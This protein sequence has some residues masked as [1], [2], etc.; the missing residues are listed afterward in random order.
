MGRMMRVIMTAG[1]V[2]NLG[3]VTLARLMTALRLGHCDQARC[4]QDPQQA[5]R[6]ENADERTMHAA[7]TIAQ[8]AP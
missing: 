8:T 2:M 4:N 3:M 1:A 5:R 6:D 7:Q